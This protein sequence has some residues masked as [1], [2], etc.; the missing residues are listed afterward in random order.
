M[1]TWRKSTYSDANGGQS[2]EV[3]D[4]AGGG[5]G[6]LM[7]DTTNPCGAVLAVPANEWARFTASPR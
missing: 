2:V 1:G 5:G 6:V 7:R 3:A 4:H